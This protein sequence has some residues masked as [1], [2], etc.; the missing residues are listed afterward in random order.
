MPN[1]NQVSKGLEST[2]TQTKN[3]YLAYADGADLRARARVRA[4][5]RVRARVRVR[6][7]VRGRVRGRVRAR[8]RVRVGVRVRVRAKAHEAHA[9]EWQSKSWLGRYLPA[10]SVGLGACPPASLGR[11]ACSVGS[12]R[13]CVAYEHAGAARGGVRQVRV[14]QREY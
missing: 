11:F 1:P 9:H 12:R 3:I 8:V 14:V 10:I 4:R 7:R 2:P 6:V 13:A 5:I